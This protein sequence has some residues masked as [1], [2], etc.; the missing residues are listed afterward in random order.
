VEWC[1][2][3]LVCWCV[4]VLVC[5]C[6][7]LLVC[8]CVGLLVCSCKQSDNKAIAERLNSVAER[9]QSNCRVIAKILQ[10][11]LKDCRAICA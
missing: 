2:G 5:W 10:R 7:G 11:L 3:V 9:L 1:V 8:W 4:G 6:V